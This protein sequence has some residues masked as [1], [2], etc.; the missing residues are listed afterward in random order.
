MRQLQI[1][2]K[3][4][5]GSIAQR[6]EML[7]RGFVYDLPPVV[8]VVDTQLPSAS[9]VTMLP[10]KWSSVCSTRTPATTSTGPNDVESMTYLADITSTTEKLLGSLSRCSALTSSSKAL[11]L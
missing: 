9:V 5:W 8:G 11:G 4:V 10:T 7:G 1:A 2:L 6:T 3:F